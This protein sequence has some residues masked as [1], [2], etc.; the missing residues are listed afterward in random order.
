MSNNDLSALAD[1]EEDQFD[2]AAMVKWALSDTGGGLPAVS[3]H[4][5]ASWLN[6]EWNDYDDG[7]GTQTNEDVLKGAWEFWTGRS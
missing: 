4:P 3:A 6:A 5:F 2:E 7:T 1:F